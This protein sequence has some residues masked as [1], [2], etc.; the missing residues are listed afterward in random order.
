MKKR[1]KKAVSLLLTTAMVL[2]TTLTTGVMTVFADNTVGLSFTAKSGTVGNNFYADKMPEFSIKFSGTAGDYTVVYTATN[3]ADEIVWRSVSDVTIGTAGVAY[4][5]VKITSSYFGVMKLTASVLYNGTEVTNVS[6]Y[7]SLSN[8]TDDMPHNYR[9]GVASQVM[10]YKDAEGPTVSLLNGAGI[11][12]LR[13]EELSWSAVEIEKGTYSLLED[14]IEKTDDNANALNNVA[15]SRT[16]LTGLADNDIKYTALLGIVNANY[17]SDG[18]GVFTGTDEEYEA[19]TAYVK[20]LTDQTTYKIDKFEV[21]NEWHNPT[22]SGSAENS[23]NAEMLAKITNAVYEGVMA[24]TNTDKPEVMGIVEDAW[25]LYGQAPTEYGT[26]QNGMIPKYIDAMQTLG[27]KPY[28]YVSLHP[29]TDGTEP[30]ENSI[31]SN[32]YVTELKQFLESESYGAPFIFSELG[33]STANI[34][35]EQQAAYIVRANAYI[36]ANDMAE[37]VYNYHVMDYTAPSGTVMNMGLVN[38][39]QNGGDYGVPYLAKDSYVALAYYNGLM[40]YQNQ[41][42]IEQIDLDTASADDYC[43]SFAPAQ[44][45]GK[46]VMMYGLITEDATPVTKTVNVGADTVI[47]ADMYGNEKTVKTTDGAV[48]VTL[49]DTPDYI[50]V[51]GEGTGALATAAYVKQNMED[52]STITLQSTD[53]KGAIY[54]VEM[55]APDKGDVLH[56]Y[57]PSGNTVTS[58]SVKPRVSLDENGTT[59]AII[60]F[61]VLSDVLNGGSLAVNVIGTE[62]TGINSEYP[63]ALRLDDK[64]YSSWLYDNWKQTIAE[65]PITPNEW[66][67]L[68]L[69]VDVTSGNENTVLYKNGVKIKEGTKSAKYTNVLTDIDSVYINAF[70]EVGGASLYLDNFSITPINSVG[71]T[72]ADIKVWDNKTVYINM[73]QTLGAGAKVSATGNYLTA[74]DG[75]RILATAELVGKTGIKLTLSEE[76]QDDVEYT[77]SFGGGTA[78]VDFLGNSYT[79]QIKINKNTATMYNTLVDTSFDEA[80]WKTMAH[81]TEPENFEIEV[82]TDDGDIIG[83]VDPEDETNNVLLFRDADDAEYTDRLIYSI[84]DIPATKIKFN[85]RYRVKLEKAEDTDLYGSF[86]PRLYDEDST[87]KDGNQATS[88]LAI[89]YKPTTDPARGV[90]YFDSNQPWANEGAKELVNN[91]S[92]SMADWYTYNHQYTFEESSTYIRP[93]ANY[94]VLDKDGKCINSV[95]RVNTCNVTIDWVDAI[96]F[97]YMSTDNQAGDVAYM[98]DLY[99]GYSYKNMAEPAAADD[100]AEIEAFFVQADGTEVMLTSS[101]GADISGLKLNLATAPNSS[102]S[103]T[104]NGE[105]ISMAMLSATEYIFTWGSLANGDY[106]L[107]VYDG[108]TKVYGLSFSVESDNG[109]EKA[110]LASNNF[111]E[112]TIDINQNGT[113]SYEYVAKDEL[114]GNAFHVVYTDDGTTQAIFPRF[115]FNKNAEGKILIS[116][117]IKADLETTNGTMSIMMLN[118]EGTASEQALILNQN[119]GSFL[120]NNWNS[121]YLFNGAISTEWNRIEYLLDLDKDIASIYI[122]GEFIK[123]EKDVYGK[124]TS[125]SM[126]GFFARVTEG[127]SLDNLRVYQLSGY[128]PETINTIKTSDNTLKAEMTVTLGADVSGNIT[129]VNTETN[130]EITATVKGVKGSRYITINTNTP[131]DTNASYKISLGNTV[132]S[133]SLGNKMADNTVLAKVSKTIEFS[134]NIT[135][136]GQLVPG[137]NL[138]ATVTAESGSKDMVI[139]IA[140]YDNEGRLVSVTAPTSGTVDS[141]NPLESEGLFI[142]DEVEGY[143]AKAI[144]VESMLNLTPIFDVADVTWQ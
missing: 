104:L 94:S 129:L 97:D 88:G 50:I 125:D 69:V 2:T 112:G 23:K 123:S 90:D 49:D 98:D 132:I 86:F 18:N 41:D 30:F 84:S 12:N 67:R 121:A 48:T 54:G 127:L 52:A 28:D 22:M 19:L 3:K 72:P 31:K 137:N 37:A 42:S 117:D 33:W 5:T 95:V 82:N 4:D 114:D 111:E 142:S 109:Y 27:V 47:L 93:K 130:A 63:V 96:Q 32:A 13:S 56:V 35:E 108:E 101:I 6:T 57:S 60:S 51:N 135:L 9:T 45:D 124:V 105:D 75:S 110:I 118:A 71:N 140:L 1:F 36:Q 116:F 92:L 100:T 10:R 65:P 87:A 11:G 138:Y 64:A 68:D 80:E 133:D 115:W 21:T 24:S 38:H 46:T 70:V 85:L 34:T 40:A 29:Y 122:N 89:N 106:T 25:G 59:K 141:A 44:T 26:A 61:D 143:S 136:N 14:G 43:Y 91:A 139:M 73:P 20:Y 66:T 16:L 81:K 55:G 78:L 103:A 17:T 53:L 76:M 134:G 126:K 128:A 62:T 83:A 119:S 102:I 7:Y 79:K 8:H 131:I 107:S 15:R 120:F 99:I 39:F 74:S 58:R 77:V 113:A 144:C